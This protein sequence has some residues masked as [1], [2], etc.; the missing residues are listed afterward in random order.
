MQNT[1]KDKKQLSDIRFSVLDLAPIVKDSTASESLRNTLDLARHAEKWGYT[2]YW[3]AEHHNMPGIASSAT[4]V[5]I[6]HVA[7]GTSTI[8][9][10]SGGIMLPNHAP[11]IIAEQFG[12]LESLFPG[13][14]DLGLGRAPGTDQL[15]A[16]A[17]RRERRSDGHDFP[18]QL[19]ELRTYFDPSMASGKMHVRA[20]PGEGLNIPIWLLGSSGFS[21]QLAGQ[22]GLPFAFASHF[23]PAHTVPALDLYRSSFRP[24][25]VLE[26]PY[27]MVGVNVIAADNEEKARRLATSMQQQF[28]NLIRNNPV[29][30]QPPVDNMDD[31][32][33]DY[34]EA[35]L[36]QQL[37]SSIIGNPD[38]IKEKLEA[39]L[40]K[41][42]ADEMMINAQIF[43]HQDR[44]RSFEIVS[45][46]FKK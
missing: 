38:T 7:A 41:T 15:T 26:E 18:E 39:F 33:S 20:V 10:G 1:S 34:E 28:L 29:P 42:G 17:L 6:G 19:E 35:A 27:A 22:L 11:L 25:D 44:L 37:G 21:A 32:W 4:S 12:T 46:V 16:Q 30:L 5:V 14:I 13:R 36:E 23:S 24:S 31:L 2:R 8:R 9:V 3:L 40:N 43:D 45:E